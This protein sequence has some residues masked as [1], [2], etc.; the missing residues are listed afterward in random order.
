MVHGAER[1]IDLRH[2]VVHLRLS[3]FGVV[4]FCVL[5]V[6]SHTPQSDLEC[7]RYFRCRYGHCVPLF[8]VDVFCR[9]IVYP[10]PCST[11]VLILRSCL[12]EARGVALDC[13]A[14][15]RTYQVPSCIICS[16][17]P[18]FT[19]YLR[20][21]LLLDFAFMVKFILASMLMGRL[22]GSVM[23]YEVHSC[24]PFW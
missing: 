7:P 13:C 11:R 9:V 23:R 21:T 12:C 16:M 5:F 3:P 19:W 22:E 2:C 17:S 8:D 15:C 1:G 4:S 14:S 6:D 10:Y 18:S 24:Q 20:C